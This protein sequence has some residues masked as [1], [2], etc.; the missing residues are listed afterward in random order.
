MERREII[1]KGAVKEFNEKGLKFTMDDVAKS[2]GMSK[3]TV[4]T[5]FCDKE[6]MFF[7]MVDYMFD[8]I[9]AGERRIMKNKSLS[10]Q[11]KIRQI[12]T[13]MPEGYRDMDFGQLYLLKD[14]YPAI[15]QQVEMRLETGWESTIELLEQGMEEGVIRR[16]RI[17]LVKIMFEATM[18]QFFRRDVL[19]QNHISYADALCEIVEILLDGIAVNGQ[20]EKL[21]KKERKNHD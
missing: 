20:L 13:V 9:K 14:K 12:L 6:T 8:S 16:I 18:E 19:I 11:E 5:V 10:T 15:Y 7:A 3:K 2:L 17:P 1:L 4:Y 21:E